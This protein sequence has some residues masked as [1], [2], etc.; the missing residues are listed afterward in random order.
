MTVY[1]VS[2]VTQYIRGLLVRDEILAVYLSDNTEARL[3]NSDG[4]YHMATPEEGKAAVAA[5]QHFL[6]MR[7]ASDED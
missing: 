4:S 2:Q 5:Q 1:T 7:A 6:D 3:M